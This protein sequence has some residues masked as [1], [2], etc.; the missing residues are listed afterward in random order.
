MEQWKDRAAP[1]N[2]KVF[3]VLWLC[4]V[5]VLEGRHG[6]R[7]PE[8]KGKQAPTFPLFSLCPT[9][10]HTAFSIWTPLSNLSI[11]CPLKPQVTR[12]QGRYHSVRG[13]WEEEER[14]PFTQTFFHFFFIFALCH[15]GCFGATKSP[16]KGQ[17]GSGRCSDVFVAATC[18]MHCAWIRIWLWVGRCCYSSIVYHIISVHAKSKLHNVYRHD[19]IVTLGMTAWV[20]VI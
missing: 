5:F 15:S 3:E 17:R 8:A 9:N 14:L 19:S 16:V 18:W 6:V 10:G 7:T 1:W 13:T 12:G 2:L 11:F 20:I 4:T